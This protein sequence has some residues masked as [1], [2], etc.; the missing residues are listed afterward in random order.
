MSCFV[1]Q[2][3]NNFMEGIGM[4]M[5]KEYLCEYLPLLAIGRSADGGNWWPGAAQRWPA[6]MLS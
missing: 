5:I 3:H 6:A 4:N 1:C 2:H